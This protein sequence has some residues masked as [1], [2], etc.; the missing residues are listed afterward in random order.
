MK[1]TTDWSQIVL[2]GRKN[3]LKFREYVPA[4]PEEEYKHRVA[5]ARKMLK[6]FGYKEWMTYYIEADG[7]LRR[8]V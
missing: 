3:S 7:S 1:N 2:G 8:I 4:T 6:R 5:L